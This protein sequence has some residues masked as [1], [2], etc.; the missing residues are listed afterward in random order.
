MISS[1]MMHLILRHE[2]QK[3]LHTARALEHRGKNREAST[4]YLRAGNLY[5]KIAYAS[6]PER[7]NEMFSTATNYER[8][9]SVVREK[10][11]VDRVKEVSPSLQREFIDSLIVS[12]KPGTVWDDIGGLSGIKSA[13]K[14]AVI[15]PLIKKNTDH[16]KAPRT[17]L[18][19]GPPGT[20]KTLLSKASSNTL[21][22][23]F[24]EAR[25][26]VLLSKYFGESTK[27]VSALFLKAKVSEPSLVFID[28]LDAMGIARA[29][30]I[31]ESTRRVLKQLLM[32]LD[33]FNSPSNDKIIVMAATNKPWDLDDAL[34]SRFRKKIYVPLPDAGTREQILG[35]HLRGADTSELNLKG[36]ADKT[37]RFSGR[38]IQSLCQ[39]AITHMVREMNPGLGE[40]DAAATENYTLH[41]RPMKQSDFNGALQ[42]IRPTSTPEDVARYQQWK[43][44]FGG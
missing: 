1:E 13:I 5:R 4:H 9:A 6:S 39:E 40:M 42:K 43:G 12:E 15:A 29:A 27:L 20:G 26:S 2:L 34:L 16:V 21:E 22:A 36:L 28:E 37:Q 32:E 11:S 25:L 30:D 35:I 18:F 44:E 31:D 41:D 33:G 7:A 14:E 23:T 10:R 24:F 38:D 8:I 3:E 17:I 19:Y